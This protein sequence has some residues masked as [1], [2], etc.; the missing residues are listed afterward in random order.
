MRN[1]Y[2]NSFNKFGNVL[3]AVE[4]IKSINKED[5]NGDIYLNVFKKVSAPYLLNSGIC[6]QD[7]DYKWLEF[8]NYNSKVR[9]TAIYNENNEIIEWYFDIA[10]S[11]GKENGIPYEDDFYLDVV[12]TPSGKVIL[13]DEDEFEEAFNR[14]EMTKEEYD[15]G[16]QIA[17]DLMEKLKGNVDNVLKFS[18]N[19]S[20]CATTDVI[21]LLFLSTII[22]VSVI[23][24]DNVF[25]LTYCVCVVVSA[26]ETNFVLI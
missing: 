4:K 18:F 26:F 7:N 12:L 15:E 6:I 8:Y 10:R 25:V 5:F 19:S 24:F 16:Y 23:N 21:C 11:I 3:E 20:V 13:L 2:A 1:K 9:M 14:K 17:N 22:F